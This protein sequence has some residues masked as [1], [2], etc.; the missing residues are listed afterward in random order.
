VTPNII[1]NTPLTPHQQLMADVSRDLMGGDISF[2]TS[3]NVALSIRDCLQNPDTTIDQL[4]RLISADPLIAAK[5]LR[6]ANCV[7][8]NPSG[9]AIT[10]VA[11]AVSRLGF[12]VVRAVSLVFAMDQLTKSD[13]MAVFAPLSNKTWEHSIQVA[14]LSRVL[15][16]R[17]GYGNADEAM[18]TGLVS[19]MGVFYLMYRAAA[20]QAYRDDRN[21]LLGLLQHA[22]ATIGER[23]LVILGLPAAIIE[24]LKPATPP[25][26]TTITSLHDVVHVARLLADIDAEWV[27]GDGEVIPPEVRGELHQ[28]YADLLADSEDDLR[29]ILS[30]LKH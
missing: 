17:L 8:L 12:N 10:S 16:K 1:S 18:L 15:A 30:A 27:D 28:E 6:M 3:M 5:L 4:A 22:S 7:T 19:D 26:G 21:L 20:Y 13:A 23:V 2:P 25:S 11:Q 29:E 9:K 24:A 14:A